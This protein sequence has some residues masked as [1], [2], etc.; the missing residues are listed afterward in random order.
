M[1]EKEA[2][3]YARE[4]YSPKTDSFIIAVAEDAYKDGATF[5]FKQGVKAKLNVTTI[6][7]APE[8]SQ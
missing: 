7:D 8:V 3:V 1:F 2:E 4:K 6:S 5:G